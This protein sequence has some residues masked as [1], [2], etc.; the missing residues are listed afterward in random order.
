MRASQM[1]AAKIFGGGNIV[2][3][4]GFWAAIAIICFLYCV[5]VAIFGVLKLCFRER[6]DSV[7]D[8][9]EDDER[10]DSRDGQLVKV[11][12]KEEENKLCDA[13]AV[14]GHENEIIEINV[15]D[16]EHSDTEKPVDQQV[17]V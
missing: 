2:Q 7:L 14:A 16:E 11:K 4:A 9:E 8:V 15:E 13:T 10:V 5:C 1:L 12:G 17:E 3:S 6:R